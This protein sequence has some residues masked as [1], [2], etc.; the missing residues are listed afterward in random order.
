VFVLY[1]HLYIVVLQ[2]PL[3]IPKS[4]DAQIPYMKQLSV[5]K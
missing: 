4:A 5:Y 3:Q 1:F 2:Y